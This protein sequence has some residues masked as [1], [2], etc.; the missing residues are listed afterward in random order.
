MRLAS[1]IALVTGAASGFGAEIARTFAR[2]GAKVVLLDINAGGAETPSSVR[3]R[4]MAA[5]TSWS[6][7]RVGPT[8]TGRCSR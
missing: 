4:A 6:T 5:S 3:W 8:A 7:M 1:K 2:E